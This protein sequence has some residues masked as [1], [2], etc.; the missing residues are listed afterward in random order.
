[1]L[2]LYL[3]LACGEKEVIDYS[4]RKPDPEDLSLYCHEDR[5]DNLIENDS[6]CDGIL[7]EDD[8]DDNDASSTI[9]AEDKDCDGVRKLDDC[10][11]TN[12]DSAIRE[13]DGDCDGVLKLDDCDDSD[14]SST[15]LAEDGD[16]DGVLTIDDCND[17]DPNSTTVSVDGDCDGVL[18]GADCDDADPNSTIV[19]NDYDCD[20]ILALDDC[21]D[22]N[23]NLH[24]ISDDSDCDGILTV[25]DC[26]DENPATI[27]DMDCDGISFYHDCDDADEN[28]LMQTSYQLRKQTDWGDDGVIEFEEIYLYDQAGVLQAYEKISASFEIQELRT[29]FYDEAGLLHRELYFYD[30]PDL[31]EEYEASYDYDENGCQIFEDKFYEEDYVPYWYFSYSICDESGNI[32]YTETDLSQDDTIDWTHSYTY[33]A[34][35]LLI[36]DESDYNIYHYSYDQFGQQT[37]E[38]IDHNKDG[39]INERYFHFPDALGA[40]FL[41]LTT[42]DGVHT[43]DNRGNIDMIVAGYSFG[44]PSTYYLTY[45]L[46]GQVVH[47]QELEGT[48]LYL[49][50]DHTYDLYGRRVYSSTEDADS[51]DVISYSYEVLQLDCP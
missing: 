39:F 47:F 25:D 9:V 42:V 27:N 38:E 17:A 34:N 48:S 19:A 23:G 11:D 30:S 6:D 22:F 36:A 20:G 49:E 10:D 13:D 46:H 33:D 1:M 44:T 5:F 18:T 4:Q 3:L 31:H 7:T 40:S 51:I 35:N 50:S 16:C 21:D 29:Y 32:I 2:P 12:P 15:I 41:D 26:D 28:N 37:L 43:R 14:P 24:E 45:N 8:C